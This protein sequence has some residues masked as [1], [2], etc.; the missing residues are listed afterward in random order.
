MPLCLAEHP[1]GDEE[2]AT[3]GENNPSK[4]GPAACFVYAAEVQPID[5]PAEYCLPCGWSEDQVAEFDRSLPEKT[6]SSP[7]RTQRVPF[8]RLQKLAA[9]TDRPFVVEELVSEQS[10]E[11]GTQKGM[12][13]SRRF[14]LGGS[15]SPRGVN[16]PQGR[17]EE[18]RAVVLSA[19]M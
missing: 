13:I 14:P 8:A 10:K 18:T 17:G 1:L 16:P 4:R 6:L 9:D 15:V 11:V 5:M 2:H 3:G 19:G 12:N 7:Q